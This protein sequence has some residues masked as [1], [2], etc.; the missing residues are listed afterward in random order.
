MIFSLI[1]K[2]PG[3]RGSDGYFVGTYSVYICLRQP[4]WEAS[5]LKAKLIT[6]P[7]VVLDH[8]FEQPQL[9]GD[10]AANLN[11]RIKCLS[12][13]DTGTYRLKTL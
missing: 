5:R 10:Y 6:V 3:T 13:L 1:S 2:T 4:F 9:H 11:A 7:S 8:N 12:R